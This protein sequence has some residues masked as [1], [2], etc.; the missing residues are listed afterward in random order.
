MISS[1]I[2]FVLG[3]GV[4]VLSG[5][6]GVGGGVIITPALH[7]LGMSMP[8][9]VATSLT[10]MVGSA[11]SGA[12]RHW[13]LG[14]TQA[15]LALFLGTL[16]IVGMGFGKVLMLLFMQRD[17]FDALLRLLYLSLLVYL[18]LS[19][20]PL[21]FSRTLSILRQFIPG[22]ERKPAQEAQDLQARSIDSLGSPS[23]TNSIWLWQWSPKRRAIAW[24]PL[25]AGAIGVGFLSSLT[26]LG[27]GF[28]YI[29]LLLRACGLNLKEAVGTSL[30]IMVFS[31]SFGA[32]AYSL[33][34]I[35]HFPSALI[36]MSGSVLGAQVGAVAAHLAEAAGLRQLFLALLVSA[37]LSMVLKT[38]NYTQSA[39]Y[40]LFGVGLTIVGYSVI[41][42]LIFAKTRPK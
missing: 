38:L 37:L 9:A 2:L 41:R 8:T 27:G 5:L 17:D 35:S 32:I 34:G 29:P 19:M 20:S 42:V 26:G 23:Q 40:V 4:G 11:L 18:I 22:R 30:A 39:N 36:L 13:R 24:L 12:F 15:K 3:L 10:Q 25:G 28:L 33:G 7:I 6:L 14:N 16:S 1:P 21:R 31:S